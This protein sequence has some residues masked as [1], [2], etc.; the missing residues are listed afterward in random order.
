M[1]EASG[2]DNF[3]NV[4]HEGKRVPFT[5]EGNEPVKDQATDIS[6]KADCHEL[7]IRLIEALNLKERSS[8]SADGPRFHATFH[9]LDCSHHA[10]QRCAHFFQQAVWRWLAIT[11]IFGQDVVEPAPLWWLH[12]HPVIVF[13]WCVRLN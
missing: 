9:N 3:L 12:E 6:A 7:S 1:D 2:I 4:T 8:S 13:H 11:V 5:G 10:S